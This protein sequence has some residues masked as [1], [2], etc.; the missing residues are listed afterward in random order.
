VGSIIFLGKINHLTYCTQYWVNC[1]H[2]DYQNIYAVVST[3]T[4]SQD[5]FSFL[6]IFAKILLS[7]KI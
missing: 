7:F 3:K 6:T 5:T 1:Y 4:T 2:I